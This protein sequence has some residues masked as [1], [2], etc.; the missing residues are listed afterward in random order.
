MTGEDTGRI[1][2]WR[3]R[4]GAH[5]VGKKE[6][7]G[8]YQ[9]FEGENDA[10][11]RYVGP[12]IISLEQLIEVCKIDLNKWIIYRHQV[13]KW[14]VG[15]KAD[16]K[17]LVFDNGVLTGKIESDGGLTVEP[18]FQVKAWMVPREPEAVR[19]ALQPIE[20]KTPFV[21]PE[22][23]ENKEFVRS[24]VFADP[25]FGFLRSLTDAKLDPMHDRRVLDIACQLAERYKPDRIDILGDILDLADWT[26]KFVR[27]PEFYW[28]TQPALL[29]THWWLSRLRQIVP[30]AVI[31]IH[32]GNHDNRMTS[33]I[34]KHIPAAYNLKAADEYKVEMP[35]AFSVGGL[36]GLD[37]LGIRW[38][39]D[40]PNDLDWLSSNLYFY[41]GDIVRKGSGS[42][43]RALAEE[44]QVTVMCGHVH[45]Q[46]K[47]TR[48]L[49]FREGPR[50]I[51]AAC[52]PCSCRIDGTVPAQS[53]RQNWNN[54][55][56][57]VEYMKDGPYNIGDVGIVDGRTLFNGKLFI[58]HDQVDELRR[59]F[60]E[61]NL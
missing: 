7:T 42:T 27:S 33:A 50:P 22:L 30:N 34:L 2:E 56:E 26:D 15:A 4:L 46:E 52:V 43:A 24:L 25:H 29:E 48:T 37:G 57:I 1:G 3:R 58:G 55:L 14:E 44:N 40:Y 10:T 20:V 8:N 23:P 9:Y 39:D 35:S 41:H 47:V 17:S 11:A 61:W 53:K 38:I 60:S 18:L 13:N 6:K 16:R 28:T 12:R 45:R 21:A 51:T 5:L 19:P 49:W 54:G 36:L 32:Q 31:T 59:A